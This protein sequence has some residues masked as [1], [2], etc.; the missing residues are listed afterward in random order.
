[1]KRFTLGLLVVLAGC[2]SGTSPLRT[3]PLSESTDIAN[4]DEGGSLD[5]GRGDQELSEA[6]PTVSSDANPNRVVFR[7]LSSK[8]REQPLYFDTS[9]SLK[10]AFVLQVQPDAESAGK[11]ARAF[12]TL[13][14]VD[15][16]ADGKLVSIKIDLTQSVEALPIALVGGAYIGVLHSDPSSPRALFRPSQAAVDGAASDDAAASSTSDAVGDASS[17]G[18]E[19]SGKNGDGITGLAY[20]VYS[21]LEL[22]AAYKLLAEVRVRTQFLL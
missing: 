10:Y 2:K 22:A 9:T 7:E 12:S 18:N 3:S 15:K 6:I 8:T 20:E 14:R 21:E 5:K 4:S 16:S 17:S 19:L 1:M 11:I 13:R